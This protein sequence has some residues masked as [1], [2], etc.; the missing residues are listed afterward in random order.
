MGEKIGGYLEVGA[1]PGE[2]VINYKDFVMDKDG[3][4]HIVF[5]PN[6]ARSLARLLIQT[7]TEAEREL[8]VLQSHFEVGK[9]RT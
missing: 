2:V 1:K 4:G 6:Q 7:A 8:R 5:S 3:A 9:R